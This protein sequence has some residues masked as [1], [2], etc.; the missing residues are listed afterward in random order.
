MNFFLFSRRHHRSAKFYCDKHLVKIILEILQLLF[1]AVSICEFGG[2]QMP[3]DDPHLLKHNVQKTYRVTHRNHPCA[4]CVR[5]S[6]RAFW[7]VCELGLSLCAEYTLRYKRTHAC[8]RAIRALHERGLLCPRP[9]AFKPETVTALVPSSRGLVRVPLCMP[10][11]CIVRGPDGA[12]DAVRSHRRYFNV[13]KMPK[14]GMARWKS[15]T[16]PAWL[17]RSPAPETL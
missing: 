2:E 5:R 4:I 9:E 16:P 11:C 14:P 17:G 7:Y 10:K 1:S 12:P 3:L 13:E 8:E 6:A 15:R